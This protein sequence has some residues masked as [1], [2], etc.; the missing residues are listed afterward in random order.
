MKITIAIIL[1]FV[2]T[3]IFAQKT[4]NQP[5]TPLKAL[6]STRTLT[7]YLTEGITDDSLKTV[8]IYNWI[9]NNISYDY[10]ALKSTKPL[11]FSTGKEILKSKKTL[12]Q[13]YCTLLVEMLDHA[14]I[15]AATI[16]GYTQSYQ[17]D[18]LRYFFESDHEWVVFSIRNKWYLCDPTW[19]SG[20][21]GRLPKKHT[22]QEKREKTEKRREKRLARTRKEQKRNRLLKKWEEKDKETE[23]EN[24]D[25]QDN[26]T[27]KIGYIKNASRHYFM[28]DPDQFLVNHLPTIPELQLRTHPVS[29]QDYMQK[30]RDWDSILTKTETE[31]VDYYKYVDDYVS[32][33]IHE[34]WLLSADD[35]IKYN[36]NNIAGLV[37]NYYNYIGVHLSPQFRKQ[38]ESIHQKE[39]TKSLPELQSL[40]DT[41]LVQVKKAQKLSKVSNGIAKRYV[42]AQSK[43]FKYKDKPANNAAKKVLSTQKK[44]ITDLKKYKSKIDDK[45]EMIAEQKEKILAESSG[46]ATP[47][48]LSPGIFPQEFTSWKDS[49][50]TALLQLDTLRQHWD[51][52]THTD[53]IY[54]QRFEYLKTAYNQS[55]FNVYVLG[56][57]PVYYDDSVAIS[58]SI[59]AQNLGYLVDYHKNSAPGMLYPDDVLKQYK[60]I[61]KQIKAGLTRM[62]KY[63][64]LNVSWKLNPAEAYL[65]SLSYQL[66]T[67]IENDYRTAHQDRRELLRLESYYENHYQTVQDNLLREK[68]Y[69]E[70]NTEYDI[71]VLERNELRSKKMFDRLYKFGTQTKKQFEKVLGK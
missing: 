38:F 62:K 65:K 40:N 11:S 24:L 43:T 57:N 66:L 45:L 8:A 2:S 28:L 27:N 31:S 68:K 26:L 22:L 37:V 53:T 29:M 56:N 41:L 64:Q 48:E 51:K 14:G 49:L 39:L 36:P 1:C 3:T 42:G 19:D 10:D 30:E 33:P 15:R 34:Q 35:G 69:K 5:K 67:T 71:K 58:D 4:E 46:Y 16:E 18:S 9:T 47:R 6:K 13:G 20:Y 32:L 12:C 55:Y 17:T 54:K 23:D 63:A 50:F 59:I 44:N 7:N 61:E 21:I 60:N 70:D 25:E 52:L